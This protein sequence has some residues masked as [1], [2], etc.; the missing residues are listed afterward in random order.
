MYESFLK[1][2]QKSY[3]VL[4][5]I[6]PILLVCSFGL[7]LTLWFLHP[8]LVNPPQ[9]HHAL[10]TKA[11]DPSQL[12][13]LAGLAPIS[14]LLLLLMLFLGSICL[15]AINDLEK[16]YLNIIKDLQKKP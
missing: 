14:S 5:I 13:K 9:V 4:R 7:L 2:R 3:K 15:V 11:M 12:V 8:E 16:K 1:K 6:S 10:K